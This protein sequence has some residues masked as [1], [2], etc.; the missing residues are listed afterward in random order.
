MSCDA[1]RGFISRREWLAPA[2][3]ALI[4][5]AALAL[6]APTG[7]ACTMPLPEPSE[8]EDPYELEV[9]LE[10]FNRED[11]KLHYKVELEVE[12]FPPSQPTNCQCAVNLGA[13]AISLPASLNVVSVT[14]GIRGDE[15]EDLIPFNGF[16]SAGAVAR[17]M[18]S[19]F[20][21]AG[22]FSC[23]SGPPAS[24]ALST[25]VVQSIPTHPR[26]GPLRD[27]A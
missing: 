17:W 12:V 24:A 2:A 18:V 21:P 23:G 27:L 20:R 25:A 8:F 26:Q 9:E 11:G 16:H 1:T 14:V 3:G 22:D 10:D 6:M 19:G 5:G 4:A 7:P 13:T 15:S